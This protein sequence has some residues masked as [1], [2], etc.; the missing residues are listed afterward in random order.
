MF[1]ISE[2]SKISQL[3]V[4]TLRYYDQLNL[5]KPA[6][7]DKFTGYRYYSA[8]QMF[9]LHRILAF[10]ELGFSLEQIR[11]MM[12]E[13]IPLEQIRGM[14]RIKQ[15][16]IQSVLEKEQARLDRIKERLSGIQH[17]GKER[18]QDVVL[19]EVEPQLVL[20]YRQKASLRQIPELFR[21]LDDYL[22][23]YGLSSLS[24]MVL[25][26]GCEESDDE[27]DMEVARVL[28]QKIPERHPF[29]VKQ[30]PEV[31]LMATLIHHCRTTSRCTASTELA[32]WIERNGYR[33]KENE[34]RREICIPHEK[35]DD[36]EAFVAEIQ[37][38]VERL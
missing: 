36:P 11:V 31:P 15:I 8:D 6:H 2:F 35:S 16:E 22:G 23:S 25:W 5:L 21:Q 30:L 13:Q 38:A 9:Q 10:K 27:I 14:F 4:K 3:S 34:P 19:K 12:D 33:M 37:I 18:S 26:H 20:S 29:I 24:Q 28:A 32:V 7:T 1:K 17:E